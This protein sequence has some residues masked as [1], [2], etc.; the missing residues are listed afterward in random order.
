MVIKSQDTKVAVL[1]VAFTC[2]VIFPQLYIPVPRVGYMGSL[3]KP[4]S[5]VGIIMIRTSYCEQ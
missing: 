4:S 5:R 3:K 1:V 2:M